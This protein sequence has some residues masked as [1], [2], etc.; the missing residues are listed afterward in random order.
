VQPFR[1]FTCRFVVAARSS[2]ATCTFSMGRFA[3]FGVIS[4]IWVVADAG[5]RFCAVTVQALDEFTAG[6]PLG[7]AAGCGWGLRPARISMPA[8]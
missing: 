5:E 6:G 7:I 3:R 8:R 2:S 1:P 4:V